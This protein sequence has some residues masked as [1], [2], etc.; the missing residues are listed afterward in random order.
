MPAINTRRY[1]TTNPRNVPLEVLLA[2]AFSGLADA[3][4][5]DHGC[6]HTVAYDLQFMEGGLH[7]QQIGQVSSHSLSTFISTPHASRYLQINFLIIFPPLQISAMPRL[8]SLYPRMYF[9]SLDPGLSQCP[10][11]TGR[12]PVSRISH[13]E[14]G[15]RSNAIPT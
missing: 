1:Q 14:R 6:I 12:P 4:A 2:F 13:A 10:C 8:V 3:M 15:A 7:K 11:A 5:Y 9:Q